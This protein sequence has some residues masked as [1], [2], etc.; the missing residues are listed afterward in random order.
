M[1][2]FNRKKTILKSE[3]NLRFIKSLLNSNI[4]LGYLDDDQFVLDKQFGSLI[5]IEGRLNEN[6]HFVLQC[7]IIGFLPHVE[8]FLLIVNLVIIALF[9]EFGYL[10]EALSFVF[11]GITCYFVIIR[12]RYNELEKLIDK[13][14]EFHKKYEH[15]YR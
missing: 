4:Y 1:F 2:C 5:R 14:L 3:I 10:Y 11:I 9:L 7:H 13:M 6:N 8:R 12:T 15:K